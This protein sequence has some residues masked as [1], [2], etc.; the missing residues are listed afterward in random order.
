MSV[1]M[2]MIGQ[3]ISGIIL[4]LLIPL[5]QSSVTVP[6]DEIRLSCREMIV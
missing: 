6:S 5:S 3:C 2:Y 4:S 1:Q